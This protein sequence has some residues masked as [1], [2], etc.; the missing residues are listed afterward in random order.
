[1]A[2]QDGFNNSV[3]VHGIV[4]RLSDLLILKFRSLGPVQ[5]IKS[6]IFHLCRLIRHDI[7][8]AC[9]LQHIY[10][11]MANIHDDIHRT[12]HHLGHAGC[13]FRNGAEYYLLKSRFFSPVVRVFHQHN[14]IV[15]IPGLQ[16]VRA[17]S[18]HV[19]ADGLLADLR[20]VCRSQNRQFGDMFHKEQI[21][22]GQV[23]L[24]AQLI[25][26]FAALHKGPELVIIAIVLGGSSPFQV[27]YH[28]LRIKGFPV[29][30]LNAV[31]QSDHPGGI[32]SLFPGLRQ[33]GL[34]IPI[35]IT[36]HQIFA[37]IPIHIRPHRTGA[38][39][40]VQSLGILSLSNRQRSRVFRTGGLCLPFRLACRLFFAL[41]R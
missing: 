26:G 19:G 1:M 16:H 3:Y 9:F 41:D 10:V 14:L 24:H 5:G 20:A 22:P 7:D 4:Q 34:I 28:S 37:D 18:Y 40:G 17:G 31:F 33:S 29:G 2:S 32:R 12:V 27:P 35:L 39:M 25:D 8:D 13:A 30:E 6:D 15:R 11:F 36:D 23:N 38:L 21:R